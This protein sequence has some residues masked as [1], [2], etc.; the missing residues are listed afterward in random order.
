MTEQEKPV[1][2][3]DEAVELKIA[4]DIAR[5][6]WMLFVPAAI[7]LGVIR[8][9]DASIAVGLAAALVIGNFFLAAKVTQLFARI[10]PAAVIAGALSGFLM[11]LILIFAAALIVRNFSFVDFNVWLLSVAIGHIALLA[12]E[13]RYISLSLGSPGVKPNEKS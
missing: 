7:I 13:T 9:L 8:G 10:T 3:I 6:S 12:W 1:P 4:S 11:R 2:V 5:R